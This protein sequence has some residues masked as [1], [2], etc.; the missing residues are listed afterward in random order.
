MRIW[1]LE[2]DPRRRKAFSEVVLALRL[3]AQFFR[4]SHEM[5]AAIGESHPLPELISLDNDLNDVQG[6]DMG[7][8]LKVAEVLARLPPFAEVMIA[9]TNAP[10]A[11]RMVD[12][13]THAGWPVARIQPHDDLA[14]VV[15]WQRWIQ[16]ALYR[17]IDMRVST[18]QPTLFFE[19]DDRTR[20]LLQSQ[21]AIVLGLIDDGGRL[22][23]TLADRVSD[24]EKYC[25]R[26][27]DDLIRSG[28][29]PGS[30]RYGFSASIKQGKL[31]RIY[32]LSTVNPVANQKLLPAE[33]I[34][35]IIQVLG[36]DLDERFSVVPAR[37]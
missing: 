16:R 11:Q 31:G 30:W 2:D 34:H 20:Q 18:A 37:S 36:M 24:P 23:L 13:L 19:V 9:S 12:D 28:L 25:F 21:D 4:S 27:H 22:I 1:I 17:N 8:G 3:K 6:H 33:W 26:G 7:E 29:F 10:A 14:W 32:R 35:C 15:E 5:I